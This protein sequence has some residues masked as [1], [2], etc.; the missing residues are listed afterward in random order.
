ME[1]QTS[2]QSDDQE[3]QHQAAAAAAKMNPAVAVKPLHR[4]VAEHKEVVKF[5]I[6]LQSIVTSIRP[7]IGGVLRQYEGFAHLWEKVLILPFS[8]VLGFNGSCF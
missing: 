8:L 6:P 1:A 7:E 3:Q 2:E 4:I 5:V